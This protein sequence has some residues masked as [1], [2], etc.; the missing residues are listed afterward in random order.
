MLPIIEEKKAW[1][2][3][4][5]PFKCTG[6]GKCCT[7]SPGYVFLKEHEIDVIAEYLG[8]SLEEFGRKYLR[9]IGHLYSLKEI[10]KEN[11]CIFLK[12][13]KC[14]I[15]PVRPTQCKTFPFWPR[16]LKD[17]KSWLETANECEG[18][19]PNAPIVPFEEIE[20]IRKVQEK[21]DPK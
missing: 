4:G 10:G 2:K 5:L 7:G 3:D 1:Y 9:Q 12:D 21:N 16:V 20:K 18:I 19:D 17:K 6:C 8:L 15:Y 13:N 14:Q 11:D